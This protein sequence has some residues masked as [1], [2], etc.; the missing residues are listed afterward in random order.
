MGSPVWIDVLQ[1]PAGG[2]ESLGIMAAGVG[3]LGGSGAR[4][5]GRLSGLNEGPE[6]PVAP[7]AASPE[8]PGE[9]GWHRTSL[10]PQFL[11]ITLWASCLKTR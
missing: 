9:G 6:L 5:S 3:S 10:H 7:S 11:W 4:H 8:L 2:H 1:R